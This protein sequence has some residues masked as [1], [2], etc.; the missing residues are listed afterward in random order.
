VLDPCGSVTAKASKS[1]ISSRMVL[2]VCLLFLVLPLAFGQQYVISTIAGGA[3][4]PT[5][6]RATAIAIP[7]PAGLATD[8]QG[9][10]FF[11]SNNCVF[12]LDNSSVVTRVAGTSRPGYSGDGGLALNAQ[13]NNPS[14]LAVDRFGNLYVADGNNYRIRRIS[15]A[16]IITTIA[17]NG[18]VDLS[19]PPRDGGPA[20]T[21]GLRDILALAIDSDGNVFFADEYANEGRIRRIS[22]GGIIS[23]VAGGGLDS[24]GD[25]E[26]ATLAKL[27]YPDGLTI[28][29]DGNLFLSDNV[30]RRVRKVDSQG[31][32]T[33]IAGTGSTGL[34]G[35]GGPAREAQLA[36][37][38]G[39]SLDGKGNLYIA[40]RGNYRVR[41]VSPNGVISTF[42]G[43]GKAFPGD[44]MHATLVNF[45]GDAQSLSGLS[46]DSDG[47]LYVAACW[48]QK[49]TPDGVLSNVAGNGNYSFG[50]DGGPPTNAQFFGPT[51]VGVDSDGNLF[52]A[53]YGNNRVRKVGLDGI[54]TTVAGNDNFGYGGDGGPAVQALLNFPGKIALDRSG[55]LFIT[56]T[57]N[58]RIRRVSPDGTITTFA[59]NGKSGFSPDGTTAL[60]ANI[61]PG[62]ITF[63]NE[64]NL[65]L[66]DGNTVR[67]VGSDGIISTVA[68]N[69]MY[70][71][72]GD[73]G[74]A[75]D[76]SLYAPVAL[77]VDPNNNL[78][79]ADVVNNRVRKVSPDGIISTIAGNGSVGSPGNVG[80]GGLAI[81]ASVFGPFGVAAD[82]AGNIF[83]CDTWGLRKVA[84]SGIIS[85]ITA[86][87]NPR[88]SSG[89]GGPAALASLRPGAL[90][91]DVAG[92]IYVTDIGYGIGGTQR[93]V[94]SSVRLLQPTNDVILIGSVRD[95]ASQSV[96][97]IS[98]GKILTIYGV[99]MGPEQ[100]AYNQAQN[101]VFQSNLAGTTV[102]FDGVPAPLLSASATQ[103]ATVVPYAISGTTTSVT[104]QYNGQTSSPYLLQVAIASPGIFA[105]NGTGAGQA[106]AVNA[107]GSLNDATHP[108]KI[109]DFLSLYVTGEGQTTPSGIDGKV[110][111]AAPPLSKPLLPV[112]VKVG[113][114]SANVIYSGAAPAEIAGLMQVVVQI[115]ASI[116]PGGYVPVE[117]RVGENSTGAGSAW[118]AVSGN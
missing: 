78:L 102:F 92:R 16:G 52:I 69:G 87:R 49:I 48:I 76:A 73:G 50:G 117:L 34:S 101:G 23:T 14:G 59:G 26:I 89:D 12:K 54:I 108:V 84:A 105:S 46:T 58:L 79:I 110:A 17:G 72:S 21:T 96:G 42:A 27:V 24:P 41:K 8:S 4:P 103:I 118:I 97:S 74:Q 60:G 66:V 6:A 90:T 35:D 25:G 13:L 10:T 98:P 19:R 91:V 81:N 114:M 94:D 55:D 38:A 2:R 51:D 32:M 83:I 77:S 115:P 30:D 7:P 40:D 111:T 62:A 116:Q 100:L 65:V 104:V 31:I 28:D 9:N 44:G 113:G 39:L 99:G 109:G 86:T 33:T 53:D 37:P 85:T 57:V 93:T 11:S 75:T 20:V 56:D 88:Q 36:G 47:N 106:A 67:K 3:P 29:G 43:G 71:F 80:D 63:D 15:A 1:R 61:N 95:A 70:G 107:D 82:K 22:T 18:L 5:P 68:G 45:C 64:G 112:T